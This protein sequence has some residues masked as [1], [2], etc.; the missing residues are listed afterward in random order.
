M[1]LEVNQYIAITT[2]HIH[3]FK[4]TFKNQYIY[5]KLYLFTVLQWMLSM[6]VIFKKWKK[7]HNHLKQAVNYLNMSLPSMF[8]GVS[9]HIISFCK[10]SSQKQTET[11]KESETPS[12]ILNAKNFASHGFSG[13]GQLLYIIK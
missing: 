10:S 4:A 9:S 1:H 3:L 12:N 5:S 7:Y 11:I 6:I 2:A 13:T 8:N